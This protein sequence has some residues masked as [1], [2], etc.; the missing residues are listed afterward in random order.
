VA[1]DNVLW[2]GA[3]VDP[4]VGDENTEAIRSFNDRVSAD[5]ALDSVML[6][7]GDG[8]TLIRSAG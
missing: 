5:P 1:V 3:V 8:L 4:D 7:I 2:S 6:S